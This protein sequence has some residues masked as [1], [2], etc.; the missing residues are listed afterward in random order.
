[1]TM[2]WK[3]QLKGNR[4]HYCSVESVLSSRYGVCVTALTKPPS[5]CAVLARDSGYP[6][7]T[8]I[9]GLLWK[10]IVVG[11]RKCLLSSHSKQK[12]TPPSNT[13]LIHAAW[14]LVRRLEHFLKNNGPVCLWSHDL[15]LLIKTSITLQYN[16]KKWGQWDGFEKWSTFV[17]Y[18]IL[19]VLFPGVTSRSYLQPSIANTIYLSSNDRRKLFLRPSLWL[20]AREAAINYPAEPSIYKCH[21]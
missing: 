6:P 16:T 5:R 4:T 10:R 2:L 11:R 8:D 19:F 17:N 18:L 3:R 21:K 9:C 7:Q 20:K 15:F 1:M 14:P 13:S 12:N